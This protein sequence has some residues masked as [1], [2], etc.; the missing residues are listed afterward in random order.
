MY[1]WFTKPFHMKATGYFAAGKFRDKGEELSVTNPYNGELVGKVKLAGPEVLDGC[2]RAGM[3]ALELLSSAPLHLRSHWLESVAREMEARRN[4]LAAILC[5]ES[6]KP[7]RLALGETDRAIQTFR[8]ASQEALR[9][10]GEYLPIDWTPAGEGKEAWI[11]WFPAGIIAGISPFNFPLNLSAH[12]IAP[13]LAAGCP[14][15][16]KP[17]SST[18]LSALA[19]AEAIQSAGL[20]AGSVSILPM[21]REYGDLLVTD[22]RFAILSFTGSPAV[23]WSMKSRA[24]KKKVILELGGNAG[25][26]ISAS[27]DLDLAIPKCLGGAF[28]YSGQVCIH[29]QRIFVHTSL[30]EAFSERF[31]AEVHSLRSGDPAQPETEFSVMID[32]A[33]AIRV[34]QWLEEAQADGAKILCGGKRQG[35]FLEPTVIT[36]THPDMKVCSLEVFGPVVTLEPF[37]EIGDAIASINEGRYGLQA[38]VFTRDIKEMDLAFR[39]LEVGGV[40]LNDVPTFRVDHMPYGGLKESGIGREGVRYAMMEMMEPRILVKPR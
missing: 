28:A 9:Q 2:I 17:S 29:T 30:I 11:R 13:A 8:I 34:E 14:I 40:I 7:L 20:P 19:M 26:I 6:G 5:S 24:G 3:D 32:E 27:A 15:I 25:A 37:D 23:G 21:N 31:V 4:K 22:P 39:N 36:Q 10:P 12:K 38:G 1:F 35:A 18:P 16:L 33:N